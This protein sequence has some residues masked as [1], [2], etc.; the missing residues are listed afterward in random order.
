MWDPW[1]KGFPPG[2]AGA[3]PRGAGAAPRRVARHERARRYG[4]GNVFDRGRPALS[5]PSPIVPLTVC[6]TIS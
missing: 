1:V 2:S 4:H 5:T 6:T 3:R